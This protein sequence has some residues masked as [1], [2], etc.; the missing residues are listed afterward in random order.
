MKKENVINCL[1]FK[2]KLCHECNKKVPNYRSCNEMY[3]GVF[4]QNY[5]WYIKKQFYEWG[6]HPLLR[7]DKYIPE[8]CPEEIISYIDNNDLYKIKKKI[9]YISLELDKLGNLNIT[10]NIKHDLYNNICELR[11]VY[12]KHI[13]KINNVVENEVRSKFGHKKIGE[14]WTSETILYYIIKKL[15][16]DLTI[17]RHYRPEILERLEL[18]I[19]I[20]D[21]KIGIEYQ[22]IQHFKPVKHWGGIESFEKLQERDKRKKQLCKKN[23]IRLIYFN[24]N[25]SLSDNI[26]RDKIQK[27]K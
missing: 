20:E 24:Y 9:D 27:Y 25:E 23:N 3:G 15:Y 22:G 4:K 12:N 13:R 18:D 19:Y 5:G 14:S 1:K 7:L 2:D 16:P 26:V 17:F 21:L 8:L 11:K 6:I 10:D